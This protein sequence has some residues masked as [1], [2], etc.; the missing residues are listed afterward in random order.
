SF[1]KFNPF[2]LKGVAAAGISGLMFESLATSSADENAT[3][4][5]LLAD[6]MQLAPDRMSMTFHLNPRARFNNGD[7]VLAADVKHSFDTLM[8]KGAPQLKMIYA[9]VK[10]ATVVGERT[11]RFDFRTR[12]H[13]L[14]LI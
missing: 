3:M 10:G 12:N 9:D 5:G 11:V 1:D 13:E 7:P 8:S 6:D 14:P 2:S 4:Y